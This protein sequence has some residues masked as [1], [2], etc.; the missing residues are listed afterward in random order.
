MHILLRKGI[1]AV[2]VKQALNRE[3]GVIEEQGRRQSSHKGPDG[4]RTR[5]FG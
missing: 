1:W 4:I 5:H 3:E 2:Y